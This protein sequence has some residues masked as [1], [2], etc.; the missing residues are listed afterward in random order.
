[1]PN[2]D[3][4]VWPTP[5]RSWN[6]IRD[7]AR[8]ADDGPWTSIWFADHFMPNTEDGSPKDGPVEECW[9]IIAALAAV[10]SRLRIGSLVSPTTFRHPAV[11]AN[12][13]ATID[14][15]Y[16]AMIDAFIAFERT[17]FAKKKR[18]KKAAPKNAK[19]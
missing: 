5:Q 14:R 16:R 3:F 7:L 9:S 6:E 12:S 17:A 11:L 4:S 15:I 10:T 18:P 2:I 19:R 8:W 13:A 1:M